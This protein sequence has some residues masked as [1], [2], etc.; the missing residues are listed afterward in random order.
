MST[1]ATA[2]VTISAAGDVA[3]EVLQELEVGYTIKLIISRDRLRI[4]LR[5]E[6]DEPGYLCP[7]ERVTKFVTD[8]RVFLTP[9]EKKRLPTLAAAVTGGNEVPVLLA[10]GMAPQL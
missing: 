8:S 5:I 2:P 3:G 9:E 4:F 7:P 10:E 6:I 1:P